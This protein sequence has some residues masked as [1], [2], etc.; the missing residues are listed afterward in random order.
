LVEAAGIIILIIF[1]VIYRIFIHLWRHTLVLVCMLTV[2]I[3]AV[4]C[5]TDQPYAPERK[6]NRGYTLIER[7]KAIDHN[8]DTIAVEPVVTRKIKLPT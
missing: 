2:G 7:G 6:I 5:I 3:L 1:I 4:G 8:G